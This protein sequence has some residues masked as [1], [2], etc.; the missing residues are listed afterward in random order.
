MNFEPLVI[1]ACVTVATVFGLM[2][3]GEPIDRYWEQGSTTA[4]HPPADTS[5]AIDAVDQLEWTGSE[6]AER[7]VSLFNPEFA[8]GEPVAMQTYLSHSR[9]EPSVSRVLHAAV[10]IRARAAQERAERTPLNLSIVIDV[11]GSMQGQKL[12]QAKAAAHALVDSLGPQDALSIVHY[13]DEAVIAVPSRRVRQSAVQELHHAIRDLYADGGTNISA[14]LTV[15]QRTLN[16]HRTDYTIDRVLLFSDGQATNGITAPEELASMGAR[17]L[18][19]GASVS[20]FGVGLHYNERVMQAISKGAGGNDYFIDD[21]EQTTRL[22][23]KEFAALRGTVAR[24]V[25]LVLRPG[26]GASIEDFGMFA[27]YREGD[28]YVV[29]LDA[30]T[31][32]AHKDLLLTLRIASPHAGIVDVLHTEL[33]YRP[34]AAIQEAT[35]RSESRLVVTA[36][37]EVANT[38]VLRRV[39]QLETL[40]AFDEA[41]KMYQDGDRFEAADM[42]DK[43]RE[44]NAAFLDEHDL[45]DPAFERV[46]RE[47]KKLAYSFRKTDQR[48]TH[49]KWIIKQKFSNAQQSAHSEIKF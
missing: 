38:N 2:L 5:A 16:K 46:G 8:D 42:M 12:H 19:N 10:A 27:H 40:A 49:G 32:D 15:G 26:R 22:L 7:G 48:S 44:A 30:L 45:D 43:Q 33:R 29:P 25:S 39:Q 18:E 6:K 34:A 24:N 36:G 23:D 28:A 17:T 20:T 41:L 31:A 21:A 3:L 4:Y 35:K 37:A 14:G 13:N 1:P 11:S 9:I 47:M